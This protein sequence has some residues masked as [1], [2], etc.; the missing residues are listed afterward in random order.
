MGLKQPR[1]T[2]T[3]YYEILD[4]FVQAVMSRWPHA[5]LQFE[6]FNLQHARP[7]LD[8][9]R[10]SH[11]VFNDDIQSTAATA[12][13]GLLGAMTVQGKTLGSLA[14]QRI[15]VVG[16]GSAGMGTVRMIAQSMVRFGLSEE[17]APLRFHVLDADGLITEKRGNELPKHVKLFARKDVESKGT[18]E[19]AYFINNFCIDYCIDNL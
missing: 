10:Y 15:V 5:I 6:D 18:Y 7:L 11:C 14:D 4:E 3:P 1:L 17:E 13:G 2:G 9:Y 12:V 19:R 16:A 8:R